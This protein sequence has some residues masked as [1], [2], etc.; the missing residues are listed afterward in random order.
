MAAKRTEEDHKREVVN[1]R[2]FSFRLNIFFFLTF[3][4]FSALIIRLAVLQFVEGPEMVKLR[5]SLST[6]NVKIPPIRG[7]IYDAAGHPI[8]YSTSTQ[9]LYYTLETGIGEKEAREMADRLARS[10]NLYKDEDAP[11]MVSDDIFKTMDIKGR[12]SY[13]FEPRRIKSGL[14][15]KEIAYFMEN[16]DHYRG[17]D[18][19]EESIRNYDDSTIAVQLVGY[20][21]GFNSL[22]GPKNGLKFYQDIY[23]EN[24]SREPEEQYLL[25]EKVGKDGLELMYQEQLRGKNGVKTY[26]VD[27]LSRIVG[28]MELTVPEKGNNLFLTIHKDVQLKTEEAIMGHLEKIRNSSNR[29][30]RA[31]YAKT[32]YAV[33]MEVKTG[34]IVAMAS[35]PDYDPNVWQKGI[36]QAEY[37]NLKYYINNGSIREVFPHYEDV[38]EGYNHPSSLVPLGSTQKPLTVLL[39]L[40]EKLFS[41]SSTYYDRGYFQFGRQGYETRVYNA[42]NAAMGSLNPSTAISRSSNAFMSEMIGNKLYMMPGSEGI[43]TW[44]KYMTEFGLG[45]LTDSDLPNESKGVLEYFEEAKTGSEQSAL[46]YASFGQQGRYT[47]LQ[48]AQ[49]TAM[50]ANHGKRMKPQFVNEIKDVDGNVVQ[51]FEPVVLGEVDIPENYWNTIEKGMLNVSVQGFEGFSYSFLRKTG[52]SQQDV[53]KR[54]KVENAV[55]I[56]AAPADDPV[57]AIAVVVPDG[58]Y[59]GYGAA[60]IARKIFDAYDQEV[61]LRGT[62]TNKSTE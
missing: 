59:G 29:R 30:E 46:I 52:T 45:V 22:Y 27:N 15:E 31:P 28:P 41:A 10:I 21:S 51:H 49:Y 50:L 3:F 61:G 40:N 12:L 55:F 11:E 54:K 23:K 1:R 6:R 20:M 14:N 2:H 53:G 33:A 13:V 39:G 56:A 58:G 25:T 16:R 34:K 5:S 47:A 18:I 48:L 24:A 44:H 38:K 36:T 8:A 4:V 9:S 42:S 62:P 7:N 43:D 32:G 19:I 37:D 17:I 35:M 26:P 60:P 57:L